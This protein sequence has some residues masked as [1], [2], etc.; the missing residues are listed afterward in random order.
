MWWNDILYMYVI[1]TFEYSM[2]ALE[3]PWC[4]CIK[5]IAWI[6]S[7]RGFSYNLILMVPNKIFWNH[8]SIPN[9]LEM[10]F[11]FSARIQKRKRWNWWKSQAK[12]V[13]ACFDQ[14]RLKRWLW[15]QGSRL[16]IY[17]SKK[18]TISPKSM[19]NS[20]Y[21]GIFRKRGYNREKVCL[22]TG[23]LKLW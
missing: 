4:M 21:N 12:I 6:V 16:F 15:D 14:V 9:L 19:L 22:Q 10:C 5:Y 11:A 17:Q 2:L 20:N 13:Y 3:L 23:L 1:H 7:Y 8:F 18:S